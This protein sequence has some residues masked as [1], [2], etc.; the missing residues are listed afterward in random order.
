[1]LNDSAWLL[2]T[3][4]VSI[5]QSALGRSDLD[6]ELPLKCKYLYLFSILSCYISLL[7]HG[8][9]YVSKESNQMLAFC[10]CP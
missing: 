7:L 1:M 2:G 5:I 4:L 9:V 6:P 3:C 8:L 10:C